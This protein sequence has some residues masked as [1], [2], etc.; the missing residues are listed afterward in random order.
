M[1]VKKATN[2]L[3]SGLLLMLYINLAGRA[4]LIALPSKMPGV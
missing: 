1:A 4:K 2:P 3:I